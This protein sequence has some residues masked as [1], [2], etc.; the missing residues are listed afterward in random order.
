MKGMTASSYREFSLDNINLFMEIKG[1]NYKFLDIKI[2]LPQNLSFLEKDFIKKI[3][4]VARRGQINFSLKIINNIEFYPKLN[5]S[6]II[7]TLKEIEKITGKKENLEEWKILLSNPQAFIFEPKTFTE[8]ELLKIKEEFDLLLI[9]FESEKI[10]EGEEM[11]KIIINCLNNIE[12][13]L[14]NID[15]EYENW[16]K[17]IEITLSKKLEEWNIN[18][19]R[20]RLLQEI[21]LIVIKSDINE[22]L[23]RLK[24]F[25][26][27]FKIDMNKDESSGKTLDFLIQ[28]MMRETNTLSSKTSKTKV[29]EY[30]LIIKENLEKIRELIYNVE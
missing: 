10:K 7:D 3:K 1:Y 18:I 4:R 14:K 22:E 19:E 29:I 28:E 30:A 25:V 17:E 11:K 9:E 26:E 2:N 21:A 6:F 13:T 20:D 24:F 23:E 8:E 27:K 12:E 15:K 16:K 5:Y